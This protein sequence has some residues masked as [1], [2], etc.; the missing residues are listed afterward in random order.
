MQ[1]LR[2]KYREKLISASHNTIA[3]LLCRRGESLGLGS[4]G[5]SRVGVGCV[6]MAASMGAMV[7]VADVVFAFNHVMSANVRNLKGGMAYHRNKPAHSQACPTHDPASQSSLSNL[8]HYHAP[9]SPRK[10]SSRH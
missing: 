10:Y 3:A 9:R 1:V 4:R 5:R 7:E 8:P 2:L 6:R